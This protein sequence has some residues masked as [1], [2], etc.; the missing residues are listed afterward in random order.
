MNKMNEN[1]AAKSGSAKTITASA[2]GNQRRVLLPVRN[3]S[4]WPKEAAAN[5]PLRRIAIIDRTT[6]AEELGYG[7]SVRS[8]SGFRDAIARHGATGFHYPCQPSAEDGARVVAGMLAEHPGITAV[9]SLNTEALGGIYRTVADLGLRIPTD[10]SVVAVTSARIA[11]FMVPQLTAVDFPA[12]LM[13]RM[14]VEFLVHRLEGGEHTP[15]EQRLLE[16][17]ITV[18]QSAGPAPAR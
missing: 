10:L 1:G 4:E 9:I 12:A 6:G 16:P 8:R 7:P 18:R 2:R 15:I 5:R 17:T 14:G 13:G 11:E 3:R